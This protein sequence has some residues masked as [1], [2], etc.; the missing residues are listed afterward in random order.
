MHCWFHYAKID[1]ITPGELLW[2]E[3]CLL[4]HFSPFS[5]DRFSHHSKGYY[6]FD[7][8]N[9]YHYQEHHAEF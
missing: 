9:Q 7:W 2:E 6:S 3:I 1:P 8:G 4:P 5:R